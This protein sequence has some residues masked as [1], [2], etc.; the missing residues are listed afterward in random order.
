MRTQGKYPGLDVIGGIFAVSTFFAGPSAAGLFE[1]TRRDTNFL[2]D[3]GESYLTILFS[4]TMTFCLIG[5]EKQHFEHAINAAD[6]ML[7]PDDNQS[8]CWARFSCACPWFSNDEDLEGRNPNC[9][10]NESGS[11]HS[12]KRKP[13]SAETSYLEGQEAATMA[14]HGITG[15]G[16]HG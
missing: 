10:A 9:K 3:M 12:Y 13:S 15:L 7:R 1:L 6:K 2:M 4:L 16:H 14:R 5:C 8:S 11:M